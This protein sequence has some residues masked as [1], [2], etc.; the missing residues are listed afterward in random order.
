[1]RLWRA[2]FG[3]DMSAAQPS[4]ERLKGRKVPGKY[5]VHRDCAWRSGATERHWVKNREINADSSARRCCF[6]P[7]QIGIPRDMTFLRRG[8]LHRGKLAYYVLYKLCRWG[9]ILRPPAGK[10]RA[11]ALRTANS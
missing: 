5:R 4:N 9:R 8:R 1:M 3:C 2:G 7:R 11:H 10:L 6:W